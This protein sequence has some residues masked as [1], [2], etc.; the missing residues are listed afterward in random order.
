MTLLVEF[1]F[2][3]RILCLIVPYRFLQ[4]LLY[5]ISAC[6]HSGLAFD[7]DTIEA[8]VLRRNIAL[9][10]V[11]DEESVKSKKK[12]IIL[13]VSLIIASILFA[14]LLYVIMCGQYV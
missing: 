6:D 14:W 4:G 9:G 13:L 5:Y 11:F 7:F 2:W 12:S 1:I 3:Q 10:N 8:A